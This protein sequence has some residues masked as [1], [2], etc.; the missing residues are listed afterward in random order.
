MI[1]RKNTNECRFIWAKI[2]YKGH[3]DVSRR[4]LH[5]ASRAAAGRQHQA[6]ALSRAAPRQ[7][8]ESLLHPHCLLRLCRSCKKGES[9]THGPSCTQTTCLQVQLLWPDL[10]PAPHLATTHGSSKLQ[11]PGHTGQAPHNRR[12]MVTPG[13]GR[14][15]WRVCFLLPTGPPFPGRV[16][17]QPVSTVPALHVP[18]SAHLLKAI[19]APPYDMPLDSTANAPT[20]PARAA[21]PS[22]AP[23]DR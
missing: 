19:S 20:F 14:L 16:C 13:Q 23:L 5:E 2:N 15:L 17:E 21:P 8:H 10:D 6:H 4:A 7:R 18:T 11:G 3:K 22:T 12:H 1:H 9:V